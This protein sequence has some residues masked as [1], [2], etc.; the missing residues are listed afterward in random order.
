[1]HPDKSNSLPVPAGSEAATTDE[2]L[3]NN[4][5][6]EMT[7]EGLTEGEYTVEKIM[8]HNHDEQGTEMRVRFEGYSPAYDMWIPQE[9]LEKS[10]KEKVQQ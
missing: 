2:L 8:E 1:M 5:D 6:E 7:Q 9:E 3:E 10:C 4:K